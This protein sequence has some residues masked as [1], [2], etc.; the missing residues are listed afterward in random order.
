VL[1]KTPEALLVHY[2][3]DLDGKLEAMFRAQGE[4]GGG[5]WSPFNRTLDRMVYRTRWPKAG[6]VQN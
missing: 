5:A 6:T 4:D 3:D 2:L 1:P